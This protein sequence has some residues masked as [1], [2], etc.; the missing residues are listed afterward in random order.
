M[1]LR[2]AAA[3]GACARGG[4]GRR[5]E[6]AGGRARGADGAAFVRQHFGWDRVADEFAA[7]VTAANAGDA[8]QAAVE[9]AGQASA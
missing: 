9:R 3:R 5:D 2:G 1:P 7:S 8:G 4:G 6:P